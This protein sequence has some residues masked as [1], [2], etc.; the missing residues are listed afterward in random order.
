MERKQTIQLNILEP[1]GQTQG[2]TGSVVGAQWLI[3]AKHCF[4]NISTPGD[5]EVYATNDRV[6]YGSP[7]THA[8]K[9]FTHDDADL[10]LV[11]LGKPIE[12]TSYKKI[13]SGHQ[14]EA[15]E[16]VAL[17]GYG[18]VD[19]E[20]NQTTWLKKATTKLD[21]YVDTYD[22]HMLQ[23]S[24]VDGTAMRGDSGGPII[25][26]AGEIIGIVSTSDGIEAATK[27]S[28]YTAVDLSSYGEW[29][30]KTMKIS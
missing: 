11:E 15:G 17:Y 12:L 8:K 16:Q 10:A 14:L 2:C 1:H 5:V 9:I 28:P 19:N 26:K 13:T 4:E 7:T 23:G 22:G 6:N 20:G 30:N 24:G 21:K 29:I 3:T 25:D 18:V 27:D